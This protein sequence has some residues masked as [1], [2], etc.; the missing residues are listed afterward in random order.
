MT[1]PTNTPLT[2]EQK[3]ARKKA[4]A[5]IRTIRIWAWIILSLLA[6][7]ALLSRCAMSKPQLKQD[8]VA[9]CI[10]NIPFSDKW[11]NDIKARGLAGHEEAVV[12]EYCTCMWIEPLDKLTDKQ[13]RTF[14]TLKAEE[15][16][17]LLG[18]VE[19]FE[20]RDRQCIAGLKA[21]KAP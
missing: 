3:A 4:K 14:G 8:V 13:I 12:S 6:A 7:T 2:E 19:A 18:G 11:R 16:L 17:A 10:Q 1:E 15:Q 9:S 5:R 21:P 20:N